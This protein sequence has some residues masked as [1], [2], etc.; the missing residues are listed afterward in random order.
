MKYSREILSLIIYPL[1]SG[2]LTEEQKQ[3]LKGFFED[4]T[5]NDMS[6][7]NR[8]KIS[9]DEL[10]HVAENIHGI[11]RMLCFK[12]SKELLEKRGIFSDNLDALAEI[13]RL[14]DIDPKDTGF[15]FDIY[16][17]DQLKEYEYRKTLNNFSIVASAIGFIP[18]IPVADF[19]ILTPIQI[20]MVSKISNIYGY[21]VDP[22][23]FLKMISGTLGMGVVFKFTASIINRLIPFIGWVVNATVA[24]A[25]TYAI[26]IIARRYIEAGGEL[27]KESVRDIWLSSYEDGKIEFEKFRKYIFVKKDDLLKEMKEYFSRENDPP[28]ERDSQGSDDSLSGNVK[29]GNDR[30]I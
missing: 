6:N 30:R 25:G 4:M 1:K 27:T 11:D 13:G 15:D 18:F 12:I 2:S 9:S 10:K 17:P 7:L 24:F 22:K 19:F 20:G 28:D 5:E 21:P 23:E 16:D 8:M 14:L 26:G 29:K 3:L